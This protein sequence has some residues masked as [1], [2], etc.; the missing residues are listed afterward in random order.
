ML[1]ADSLPSLG[2]S[3]IAPYSLVASTVRSRRP[4][5]VANQSPMISSVHP[6]C[7][8]SC[9]PT[10]PG[11]LWLPPYRFAVSKKFMPSSWAWSMITCAS[12]GGVSGPKF[13]VPRHR[14]LTDSP[15][16]PRLV[17]SMKPAFHGGAS[18]RLAYRMGAVRDDAES[19]GVLERRRHQVSADEQARLPGAAIVDVEALQRAVERIAGDAGYG[20][21]VVRLAVAQHARV[22]PQ[23][24]GVDHGDD[25][26]TVLHCQRKLLGRLVLP[27]AGWHAVVAEDR[28]LLGWQGPAGLI[29]PARYH[30]E[31]VTAG[32][33]PNDIVLLQAHAELIQDVGAADNATVAS[34]AVGVVALQVIERGVA[35]HR[36]DNQA[37]PAVRQLS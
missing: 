23:H 13:M 24:S 29:W 36:A 4:P 33:V 11:G 16:R 15:D 8:S 12:P 21:R 20:N 26:V 1:S 25:A 27:G 37:R 2:Q 34:V 32:C 14:R 30:V 5:P 19:A 28:G 3:P 17:Y 7:A 10:W 9:W 6:T 22:A 35:A 31:F 18:D